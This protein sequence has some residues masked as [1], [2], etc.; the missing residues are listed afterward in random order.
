M[1]TPSNDGCPLDENT[2]WYFSRAN[3][4]AQRVFVKSWLSDA[5][6]VLVAEHR[7]AWRLAR[8]KVLGG[9]LAA[10]FLA[11]VGF[12]SHL[13]GRYSASAVPVEYGTRFAI[14]DYGAYLL[15]VALLGGVLLA[16]DLG[17][18]D[19][20][21]RIGE[22]VHSRPIPNTAL[23]GGR[24]AGLAFVIWLQVVLVVALAQALGFAARVVDWWMGDPFEAVSVAWFLSLDALPQVVLV[25]SFVVCLASGVR[26][27]LVTA[28]LGVLVIALVVWM[29]QRLPVYLFRALVPV[30]D[31]GVASSDMAPRLLDAQVFVQRVSLLLLAVGLVVVGSV[32]DR[33]RDGMRPGRRLFAALVCVGAGG[34]G[35]AW[36]VTSAARDIEVRDEWREAHAAAVAGNGHAVADVRRLRGDVR[37]DP[38]AGLEMDIEMTLAMMPGAETLLFS[39]N[40]GIS[41]A[42]LR[43]DGTK[44]GYRHWQG[45]LR[46]ELAHPAGS[47]STAVMSL[48]ATGIPD[49]RFGY[50]DSAVDPEKTSARNRIRT[51]GTEASVFHNQ[52][53][54]LMPAVRWLP[55]PG[56]NVHRTADGWDFFE[57]DLTVTV[58]EGWLVAGPGRRIAAGGGSRFRFRPGAPVRE[59][60]LFAGRF[61]RYAA[62]LDD[63]GVEL[64]LHPSHT[65]NVAFFE[66][67]E[68]PFLAYFEELNA[69][70]EGIGI[71]YPYDG[72]SVVETPARLRLFGGGWLMDDATVPPGVIPIKETGFPTARFR[73]RLQRRIENYPGRDER[74]L[75]FPLLRPV[76]E[77][78]QET[79]PYLF[80]TSVVGARGNGAA[81]LDALTREFA[82]GLLR[83]PGHFVE[84]VHSAHNFDSEEE[85]ASAIGTMGAFLAGDRRVI[86]ANVEPFVDRPEVWEALGDMRLSELGLA[87]SPRRAAQVL[88]LKAALIARAAVDRFGR[89]RV[90]ALL[91]ALRI[92][93]GGGTYDND[94]FRTVAEDV[95]APVSVLFGPWLESTALPGF[96]ASGASVVRLEDDDSGRYNT[97]VHIRNG[98]PVAGV[99]FLRMDREIWTERTETFAVGPRASVEVG[100]TTREPPR[101]LWLHSYLSLNRAPLRIAVSPPTDDRER[102]PDGFEGVRPSSWSPAAVDGVVVDDLD[103]GFS[104]ETDSA[105]VVPGGF[106]D[107]FLPN[108]H[109]DRG[110]PRYGWHLEDREG[111]W[112]RHAFPSGWGKYRRT[113]VR[114]V[115]GDGSE[116][117]VL[118]AVLPAPGRWRLDFHL[119]AKELPVVPGQSPPDSMLDSLGVYHMQVRSGT[120]VLPVRFDATSSVEGWNAIGVFAIGRGRTDV[121]ISSRAENGAVLVDAIRWVE[122]NAEEAT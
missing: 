122:V 114:A 118:T 33:R 98:E 107:R 67:S 9:G 99:G 26:N 35:M 51:L 103:P 73:Q 32:L 111:V 6:A 110:L 56:A 43:I 13:H 31:Y 12:H 116:R 84:R 70:A 96:T 90:G 54:A 14:S 101:Q 77:R 5:L 53:V 83:S 115:R 69:M 25:V 11:V 50:L 102:R 105:G 58:P 100:W 16:F 10:I 44:V 30:H 57:L 39:L 97:R 74:R 88:G 22:V 95:G 7:L 36:V 46:V 42:A 8:T 117:V 106:W 112:F 41:V 4:I 120:D 2:G 37:I 80:V 75:R 109:M 82:K 89:E 15:V 72:L 108:V 24:V 55:V 38:G 87:R 119:P 64:L 29:A 59:V 93:F 18:R 65:R 48:T 91:G 27:R 62:E 78:V 81:A 21:E 1:R 34:A 85:I 79:L 66:G 86:H 71:G 113:V 76:M 45:L 28:V 52:H 60:A 49:P 47:G 63:I 68:E 17:H 94:D 3:C 92:R 104:V 40:P 23:L 19:D 61:A 121:V 20:R